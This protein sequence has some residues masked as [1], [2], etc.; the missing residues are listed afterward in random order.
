MAI[1]KLQTSAPAVAPKARHLLSST[2]EPIRSLGLGQDT[3]SI[4]RKASAAPSIASSHIGKAVA[5]TA[6]APLRA[7]NSVELFIDGKESFSALHQLLESAQHRIDMEYFA[8]FNDETGNKLADKLISKA[9]AGVEVNVLVNYGN[10]FNHHGVTDRMEEAGVRVHYFANGHKVAILHPNNTV[11]HRKITLVDGKTAMTGGMNIGDPYS[12]HW[13][14]GMIKVEG[15]SV[16]DFYQAFEE[17]WGLSHGE[18][19][20]PT[21]IDTSLKGRVGGQLALTTPDTH[22]IKKGLIAAFENAEKHINI[23]SPYFIDEEIVACLENACKRGVEVRAIMPSKGDNPM[24]DIMNDSVS[25]R[26]LDAGA[27]VHRFDTMNYDFPKH[28]H[29][30][31]HFNHVK[32]ASV[33]GVWST[34]GT[35]NIDARSMRMSQE[36][37]LHI[38]SAEFTKLLDER[39]FYKDMGLSAKKDMV[40]LGEKQV[41]ALAK[42]ATKVELTG[43]KGVQAA[44]FNSLRHFF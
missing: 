3:L 17:N 13:H 40:M 23:T 41:A 14:D 19:L 12:K 35:A 4:S 24:V 32:A 15:P 38:D 7:G 37:M 34:F 20:R 31:D 33:D 21:V 18:P 29:A 2:P 11:D 22:E 36:N 27:K 26:L 1:D 5:A 6:A 16:Q 44:V 25:N 9:K 42:A 39:L 43:V 8:I 28:D 30:T 10:A